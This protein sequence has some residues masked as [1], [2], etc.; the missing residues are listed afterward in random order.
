MVIGVADFAIDH[1]G[2]VKGIPVYTYVFPENKDAGFKSYAVAKEILG[3][4]IEKIGPYA[5]KKLA[6]VQSKTKF[7]GMENADAIFYEENSVDSR[8]IE[9]LMAHEIA[10]QWFGDAATEKSF[11]HLW[12]SEGFATFM[13]NVYLESKYGYG[14]L[15]KRLF[16]DRE[17]VFGFEKT[18]RV[19]VVDTEIK[20]NYMQLLNANSYQ[21]GGWVLH[22]LWRKLGDEAFWKG[23][24]GYYAEYNGSN[25]N[26]DDFRTVM[27][28]V[29][30]QNLQQFFKQWLYTAGHPQLE[31]TWKY[32]LAKS[33]IELNITQKQNSLFEFPL[34]ISVDGQ[35][36]NV[37]IKNK[38]T[39]IRFAV[40][41]KPTVGIDPNV[42]LLA[43][44]EARQIQ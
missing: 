8:G 6:N 17:I 20:G 35:L 39:V 16:K 41:G 10:H 22:M 9:E 42:N 19:P 13:A 12:L 43:E 37:N 23:I 15:K 25:A 44:F 24:R 34:E 27:E 38:N 40:K 26:T 7:G 28:K 21:K 31:I 14:E 3:Y 33:A 18:M 2:D 4:Y 5:Y 29:S 11:N 32:D 1:T 36:H 30:G